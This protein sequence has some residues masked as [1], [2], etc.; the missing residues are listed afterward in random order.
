MYLSAHRAFMRMYLSVR[1]CA[2]ICPC[3]PPP[4]VSSRCPSCAL[5]PAWY[6]TPEVDGKWI[7]WNH[8]VLPHWGGPAVNSKYPTIGS[9]HKPPEKIGSNFYPW[10]GPYSSRNASVIRAHVEMM[11]RAGIGVL[12]Y[13]WWG[14]VG[15]A[16]G[17][18]SDDSTIALVASACLAWGIKLAFHLEPYKGRNARSVRLDLQHLIGTYGN[19]SAL[20]RIGPRPALYVYDSYHTSK[21]EWATLLGVR[22]V[23]VV[24]VVVLIVVVVVGH[25]PRGE[26]LPAAGVACPACTAPRRPS[27]RQAGACAAGRR[28]EGVRVVGQG[29]GQ[30][31]CGRRQGARRGKGVGVRV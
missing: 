18:P 13:S 1:S 27:R 12:V 29:R 24:E 11:A 8:E 26:P 10:L 19:H 31:A 14:R 7:H 16:N 20:Y 3:M 9:K 23:V 28:G 17:D 15:D 2:C 6:G 30:T 5:S 4:Q 22:L 21:E 25:P